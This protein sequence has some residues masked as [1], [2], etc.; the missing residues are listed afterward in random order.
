MYRHCLDPG[1]KIDTLKIKIYSHKY[2][3]RSTKYF[4]T[5][6]TQIKNI[7]LCSEETNDEADDGDFIPT[8]GLSMDN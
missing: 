5:E 2:I 1:A 4:C 7:S 3:S 8:I 6:T